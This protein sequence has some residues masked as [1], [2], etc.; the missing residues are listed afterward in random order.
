VAAALSTATAGGTAVVFARE[1]GWLHTHFV[2]A[3]RKATLPW[4]IVTP[5]NPPL[6]SLS[7]SALILYQSREQLEQRTQPLFE[8]IDYV[9]SPA[10]ERTNWALGLNL[11]MY[12]VT[13]NI[14]PF[15]PRNHA[16]LLRHEACHTIEDLNT[17]GQFSDLLSRHRDRGLLSAMTE[18]PQR[19]HNTEG[20]SHAARALGSLVRRS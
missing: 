11:P 12:V 4:Q 17:A 16:L 5:A 2:A 15:A 1:H 13:P 3:A 10:H 18:R 19:Y 8:Y 6:R 20:F 9:V 14:G 7:G